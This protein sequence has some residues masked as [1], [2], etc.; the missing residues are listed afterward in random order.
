MRYGSAIYALARHRG[1][2]DHTAQDI[3]QDVVVK[4]FERRDVFK[5][6]PAKGRFRDW[7]AVVVRNQVAQRRRSP[8]ERAKVQANGSSVA[9]EPI[10]DEAQPDE[11]WEHV[12]ELSML[13]AMLDVVR[14]EVPPETYM[15]FELLTLRQMPCTAVRRMTGMSRATVYRARARVFD[16]LRTLGGSYQRDGQLQEDVRAAMALRPDPA[17]QRSLATSMQKTVLSWSG[18]IE[19]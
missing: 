1:C 15:A 17:A 9:P 8:S 10:A 14:R 3:V 11:H 18:N 4:I 12:F 7:L 13:A 6:D 2:S 16:R 19:R 5:Y